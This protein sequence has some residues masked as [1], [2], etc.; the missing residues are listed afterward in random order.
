[1]KYAKSEETRRIII[2]SVL[3]LFVQKGFHGTSISDI[4]R[5]AKLTKG[6][7]YFHFRNKDALLKGVLEEYEKTWLDRLIK[8]SESVE[9]KGID[10]LAHFL[11]FAANFAIEN[12]ELC[13]CLSNLSTEL[14]SSKE[15]YYKEMKRIYDKYRKFLSNLFEEGKKDGSFREDI[16]PDIIALNLIGTNEGNLSQWNMNKDRDP[17]KTFTRKFAHSYMKLMLNG[18]C[19]HKEDA[20]ACSISLRG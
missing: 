14:C 3:R 10:K 17:A 2:N 20:K 7:I 18:V 5:A 12:R 19:R 6:A 9:G 11:R 15:K 16:D 4:T 1:V 8:A 13:L